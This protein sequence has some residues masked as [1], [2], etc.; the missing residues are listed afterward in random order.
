[1]SERDGFQAGVPCWVDTW[2][3]DIDRAVAYY[4]ALF[5][6]E[7]EET[8]PPGAERRHF[9]MS[10]R[11]RRVT[12]IGSPPPIPG[13]TP[14]WGTYVWVDDVD[15]TVAKAREAGGKVI[16]EPFDALDGGRLA[17]LAD[18]SGGVIAA[19]QVGENKGAQIVN[20]PSAWSMSALHTRDLEAAKAF[21]AAV[22]GWAYEEFEMGGPPITLAL[23][24]GYVGGVPTQPVPRSNVA[25][26]MDAVAHGIPEEVP[27]YWAVDFWIDDL[28]AALERNAE[29]GGS[30]LNPPVETP[31]FRSAVLADPQGAA[32]NLSQLTAGS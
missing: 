6:W 28:D 10:M 7:A 25:V 3:P 8:S 4:T 16:L 21:Y 20:E 12:G 24:E 11:G 32:F 29:L 17:L 5:S 18:P 15:E 9:M 2:Q 26:L 27:S 14:V 30:V 23:V 1:M 31:A 19:W 13:H 22:F